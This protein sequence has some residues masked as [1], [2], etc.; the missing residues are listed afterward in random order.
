MITTYFG[1]L[2]RVDCL[3]LDDQDSPF[4]CVVRSDFA[5][6]WS[7]VLIRSYLLS[8]IYRACQFLR[9]SVNFVLQLS[10]FLF[11]FLFGQ[12]YIGM[13]AY[14]YLHLSMGHNVRVTQRWSKHSKKC[15]QHACT[16]LLSVLE[17][18]FSGWGGKGLAGSCSSAFVSFLFFFSPGLVDLIDVINSWSKK[19]EMRMLV[20]KPR[21]MNWL[22]AYAWSRSTEASLFV[23]CRVCIRFF[24]LLVSCYVFSMSIRVFYNLSRDCPYED[25]WSLECK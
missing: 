14:A 8:F 9:K 10:I 20:W 1:L 6:F 13:L 17:L 22:V 3:T 5:G 12:F 25:W 16:F 24:F 7:H 11:F 21:R 18:C 23:A 19:A 2:R 15:R 4:L